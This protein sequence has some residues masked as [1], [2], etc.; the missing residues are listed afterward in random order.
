MIKND[1]INNMTHELKTPISTITLAHEV[2]SEGSASLGEERR[3]EYLEVIGKENKRLSMLVDDVLKSAIWESNKMVIKKE[4]ID[5]N[6]QVKSVISSFRMQI[7]KKNIN[8][9]T[10]LTKEEIIIEGDPIHISN[11]IFNLVDNAIKYGQENPEIT[12]T[13]EKKKD[14]AILSVADNGVG[15][16][17]EDQPKVFE[18]FY[19]VST[20]NVHDVKG[21][22]LGLNYVQRIM[23]LHKGEIKLQSKKNVG[24]T[25]TLIFNADGK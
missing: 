2:L 25:I 10:R 7:E 11:V 23:E 21:F 9:R 12:I 16:A 4:P 14:R 19:R 6:Q 5:L 24:T 22:G 15:I 13:T 18:K 3:S 1:F 8:L 20:G 17:R